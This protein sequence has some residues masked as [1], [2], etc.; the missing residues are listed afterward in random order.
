MKMNLHATF[1]ILQRIV[2]DLS[3]KPEN[4]Y[5]IQIHIIIPAKDILFF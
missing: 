4:I 5:N 2:M 1:L 3:Q